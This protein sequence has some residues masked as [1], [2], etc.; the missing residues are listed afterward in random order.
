MDTWLLLLF[1]SCKSGSN[2]KAYTDVPEIDFN[3]FS[4]IARSET[5]QSM[6]NQFSPQFCMVPSD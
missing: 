5:D 1:N 6:R 4:Y 3:S 2:E